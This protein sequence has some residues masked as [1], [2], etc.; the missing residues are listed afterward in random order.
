MTLPIGGGDM[1]V[2][3]SFYNAFT[4]MAVGFEGFAVGNPAL[5]VAGT[6]VGAAG[7][8]LTVLMARAMNRSVWSVLVGA[9][10]WSRRRA[11][12][13]GASSPLTW[14]TPP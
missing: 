8:L 4:G 12:S 10:A 9:S 6:L 14:R 13:R 11:R 7:T 3:I 2:A 5:M 1:P